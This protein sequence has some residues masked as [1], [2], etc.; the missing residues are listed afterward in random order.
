MMDNIIYWTAQTKE[1]DGTFIFLWLDNNYK[2]KK[3]LRL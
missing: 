3:A 1:M 2:A